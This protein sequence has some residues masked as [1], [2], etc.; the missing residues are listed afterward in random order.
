MVNMPDGP[1]GQM[2]GLLAR[3]EVQVEQTCTLAGA[4]TIC[5]LAGRCHP[6]I[7]PILCNSILHV[8]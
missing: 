8:G 1:V 6:I 5:I 4:A 7:M 2:A 3:T